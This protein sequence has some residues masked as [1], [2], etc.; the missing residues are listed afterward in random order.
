MLGWMFSEVCRPWAWAQAKYAAG[1]G[2]LAGSV[3]HPFH[4]FGDLKSVSV[5]RTS[6]GTPSLRN[7][8]KMA[9]W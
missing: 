2:N 4:W 5:T 8:G 6:S 1:F 9:F 7:L 3:S